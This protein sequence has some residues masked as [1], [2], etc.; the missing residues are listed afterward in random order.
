[1]T[2]EQPH[3][4][5]SCKWAEWF[6]PLDGFGKCLYPLPSLPIVVSSRSAWVEFDYE[7]PCPTWEPKE[8]PE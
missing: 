3:V 4:C 6:L 2:N 7:M 8:T 5:Q 1:M